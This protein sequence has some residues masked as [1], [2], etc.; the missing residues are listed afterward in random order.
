MAEGRHREQ[1]V[2]VLVSVICAL[3]EQETHHL[4]DTQPMHDA[5][6]IVPDIV[7]RSTFAWIE[8]DTESPLLPLYQRVVG[9]PKRRTFRL[10]D[11]QWLQVLPG[12][13]WQEF[14]NIVGGATVPYDI[15]VKCLGSQTVAFSP[16]CWSINTDD[17][18]G[19]GIHHGDQ[20]QGIGIEVGIR[21]ARA[22]VLGKAEALEIAPILIC[23]IQSPIR[24]WLNDHFEA[25]REHKVR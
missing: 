2:G 14:G 19:V 17:L 3:L 20:G 5:T 16:S 1:S 24:P 15:T 10:N 6:A 18:L 12:A 23:G 22:F 9:D 4:A 13:V 11:I 7:N 25:F 21:V 8:T